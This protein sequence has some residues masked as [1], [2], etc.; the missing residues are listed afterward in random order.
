MRFSFDVDLPIECDDEYWVT[1]DP[2]LAFKQPI[3]QPST[4]AFFN[5]CIRLGR[6]HAYALRTIVRFP[7]CWCSSARFDA[8]RLIAVF[9]AWRQVERRSPQSPGSRLRARLRIKQVYRLYPRSL[10]V[11]A[12]ARRFF[13]LR[14]LE[15]L[16]YACFTVKW[17]P[18]QPNLIFSNQSAMLY[19]SYYSLQIVVHRPFIPLPRKPSPLSFPSLA[20]CTNAAR[21]CIHILD[22]QYER[23]GSA[24]FHHWHQVRVS[25]L[26]EQ[27]HFEV[28]VTLTRVHIDAAV[29]IGNC[30]TV[31]HM[32]Q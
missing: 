10:Y 26:S 25:V 1:D 29:Y 8:N 7:R 23:I 16:T 5:C 2:A 20:I 21:S 13:F 30:A 6:L 28:C 22:R 31:E 27:S 3:E 12:S 15:R 24:L 14:K 18:N 9:L 17:D 19:S 11:S 32:E 4:C